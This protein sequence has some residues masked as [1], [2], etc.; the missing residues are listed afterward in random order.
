MIANNVILYLSQGLENL[1]GKGD[2]QQNKR[3]CK[4]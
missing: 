1:Y 3:R 4:C 2:K